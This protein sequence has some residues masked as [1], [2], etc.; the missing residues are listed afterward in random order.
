MALGAVSMISLIPSTLRRQARRAALWLALA[1]PTAAFAQ[2]QALPAGLDYARYS[3]DAAPKI[4]TVSATDAKQSAVVIRDL[5]V[6]EYAKRPY[7][8]QMRLYR[9][10]HRCIRVNSTDAIERFNKLVIALGADAQLLVMKVRTISPS[11]RVAEAS[12]STLKE[13]KDEDGGRG[14]KIFAI[15]GIEPGGE[16]EF[17]YTTDEEPRSFGRE[18][19]QSEA[20]I[21]EEIAEIISPA[22]LTFEAKL[23]HAPPNTP[24]PRDSLSGE[25]HRIRVELKDVVGVH[26]E[27][28]VNV[29]A[30]LARLEYK[31]AYSSNRPGVRLFTWAEA[32][33]ALHERIY[34]VSK[35]ERKAIEKYLKT[36]KLPAATTAD[37]LAQVRALELAVK[38]SFALNEGAPTDLVAVLKNRAA[39]EFGFTHFFGVLLEQLHI[40]HDLIVTCDRSDAPFD[41]DF[42]TW[43]WLDHYLIYLPATK[44]LMT[45]GRP[46]FRL[47]MAPADWTAT[48]G[49][50]IKT[51][52]LGDTKSAVGVIRE[53]PALAADKSI[54][55]HI[56]NVNFAPDLT[57]SKV[58]I[59][60]VL[61]GYHCQPFQAYYNLI[62]E[63]KRTELMQNII[64]PCVPDG[65]FEKLEVSNSSA[66]DNPI[67]NPFTIDAT[68]N[69]TALVTRAG[70][71][72]LFKVG[73]LIGPQSELYQTEARQFDV[74]NDHNRRYSRT[75]TFEIP[76]G[77]RIRNLTD[78][79]IN[80]QAGQAAAPV[81]FFKSGAEQKDRTV[82][83][84]VLESYQQIYW[85][86]QDFEAYR[87]VINAA[88]NFNKVVLVLEKE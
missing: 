36:V 87:G 10:V 35:D 75:I 67:E 78:L 74:E 52:S 37:P 88:A 61:G 16:I 56:I 60:N 33:Q 20:P 5:S 42:D 81:Y 21:R 11:G 48:P 46:D 9:L 82:T 30:Q 6:R 84:N 80:A 62:P 79:T 53:I 68:V 54:N 15:E 51:V 28:F 58:R 85:P 34:D 55:D 66:N 83:V 8:G 71:K 72:Y 49:L 14:Y 32:A 7:D 31:L 65:V 12:G 50:W 69:S 38:T 45:P 44:Q 3:W 18:M 70:N 76:A 47:G 40:E 29:S 86:K 63:A 73:E 4:H 59:K 23:Y 26:N 2:S 24:A 64:K 57:S 27:A 19:L 13:L 43:N 25:K 22:A 39:S 41:G 17:L 1:T 77:F